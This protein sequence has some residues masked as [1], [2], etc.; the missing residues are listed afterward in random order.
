MLT[1][2]RSWP[3]YLVIIALNI[4]ISVFSNQYSFYIL[5]KIPVITSQDF[6]NMQVI[7]SIIAIVIILGGII[8]YQIFMFV[9]IVRR[10]CENGFGLNRHMNF[11]VYYPFFVCMFVVLFAAGSL[12]PFSLEGTW[13]LYGYSFINVYVFLLQYLYYTPSSEL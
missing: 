10:G 11:V 4:A 9:K 1:I 6:D 8:V 12:M 3:F 5:K 2:K 7:G 13:V